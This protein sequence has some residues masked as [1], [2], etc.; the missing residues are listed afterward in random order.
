MSKFE[1]TGKLENT[2]TIDLSNEYPEV[3]G[4]NKKKGFFEDI[5][6]V[7]HKI[8]EKNREINITWKQFFSRANCVAMISTSLMLVGAFYIFNEGISDVPIQI[9]LFILGVLIYLISFSFD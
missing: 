1:T 2:Q 8:M 3:I 7:Y 5:K 6:F 9:I 4:I